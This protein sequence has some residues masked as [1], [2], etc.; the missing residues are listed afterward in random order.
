MRVAVEKSRSGKTFGIA[1][2]DEND[3]PYAAAT[4]N[5]IRMRV[6]D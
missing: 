2:M 5:C 4:Y 3:K 1:L 6:F